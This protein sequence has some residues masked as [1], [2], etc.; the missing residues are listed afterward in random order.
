MPERGFKGIWIPAAVWLSKD[1]TL[2]EKA[3]FAEIDSLDNPPR[4]CIASN[5]YFSLFFDLSKEYVS[6]QISKLEAKKLI[7]CEYDNDNNRTIRITRFGRALLSSS[8][9]NPIE[10]MFNTLLSNRSI[11]YCPNEQEAIEQTD[12]HISYSDSK[13]DNKDKSKAQAPARSKKTIAFVPP[14]A[15]EAE[16]YIAELGRAG[17]GATFVDYHASRGWIVGRAAMKDWRAAARTWKRNADRFASADT[18]ARPSGSGFGN[19]VNCA[20]IIREVEASFGSRKYYEHTKFI[21]RLRG[22]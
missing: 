7:N 5:Q 2:L 11:G 1:L 9:D 22:R 8:P 4:G 20:A 19:N 18:S 13:A 14:T 3:F 17:E 12:K 15:E 6:K 21:R 10:Q 16:A